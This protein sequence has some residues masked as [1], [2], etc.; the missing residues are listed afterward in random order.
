MEQARLSGV[1]PD[2]LERWLLAI[3]ETW[4]EA[5]PDSLVEPWD[6]YF[7]NG[8]PPRALGGRIPRGRL[9]Q[10]NAEVYAALGADLRALNVQ[11]DLEP[12]EGKS[13]VAFCTFGA[14]PRLRNGRW[15]PGRPSVF[16]TY[17]EGGLDNLAELLHE[18]G[19]AIHIAAIRTRPAY[20]DWPDS[21]PFTEAIADFVALDVER[22]RVAAALAG[23]LG[24]AGR[25]AARSLRRDRSGRGVVAARAGAAAGSRRRSQPGV[26]PAHPATIS[27][28][29]RTRSC[30]GGRCGDSWWM[31]PDT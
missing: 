25:R 22:A 30:R 10:L 16:A 29:G 15:R 11:Y 5:A 28:S 31:R 1:P 2:S 12:R 7:L 9:T 21:D 3:L 26:D 14:R 20:A 23:R 4:R 6:W 17:R 24:A 13:P 18:T 27:A 8:G 19:H